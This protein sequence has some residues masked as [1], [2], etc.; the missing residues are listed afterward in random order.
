MTNKPSLPA[1][2][3][4]AKLNLWHR[5]IEP[6]S[7]LTD[8]TERRFARVLA[9]LLLI[10]LPFYFLPAGLHAIAQGHASEEITYYI[11]SFML[12]TGAYILVRSPYPRFGARLAMLYFSLLPWILLD[13]YIDRYPSGDAGKALMWSVLVLVLSLILLKP[14]Q[15]KWAVLFNISLYL[16]VPAMSPGLSYVQILPVLA[17]LIM[18]GGVLIVSSYV[19]SFYLDRLVARTAQATASETRYREMFMGSPV[20]LWEADFSEIKRRLDE[21]G[22]EKNASLQDYVNEHPE[23]MIGAASSVLLLDANQAAMELYEADSVGALR[24]GL[25]TIVGQDDMLALRDGVIDLWHGGQNNPVETTHKTLRGNIKQVVVR[26]AVGLGYDDTWKRVLI[27]IADVTRRQAAEASM[28][29]LAS[30]IE[31]SASSVVITDLDGNIEYVN[32]AFSQVTG[33][34]E[35]EVL[36]QNPRVLKSDVHDEAFY[37]LMW[38]TLLDGETWHGEL[39]NKKKNGELYWERAT[40]S[41]V[42]NDA[43][44]LVSYVAV[45]D[46]ITLVKQTEAEVRR[47]SEF[48]Q[49]VIDGIDSP[50]YVLNVDDYSIA[51]ANDKAQQVGMNAGRHNFCYTLT[52]NRDLPCESGDHPCPL[53]HVMQHKEPFTVEHIHYRADGSPYYVEVHGYPIY[54]ESGE[55][56]QMIE[57]SLDITARN[58]AERELRKLSNAVEQAANGIVITD[59]DGIIE[60]VNPAFSRITGYAAEEAIGKTPNLLKSGEHSAEYYDELWHTIENGNVWHGELVNRRRDGS[61]YWESQVISPVMN[62]SGQVTHYVAVKEDISRRKELEKS[63]TL[64]HE[65]ALVASDLKTKLLANVSHDMRT[66]LGAILGY[67]EMLQMGVFEPLNDAQSEATR[68]I[69]ASTQRLLDFVNNLLSQAQIETGKIVLNLAPFSPQTLLNSMGTEIAIARTKGLTIATEIDPDLPAKITSDSY[70]LGQ[71]LHNLISNAIKF[72]SAPGEISVRCLRRNAEQWELRITDTGKGIPPDA[73]AYI[74]ESFRQV[75]GAPNR[76]EHTGSGLGLSIVNHLVT[77]LN[78]SIELESELGV[79]ST[80]SIVLPLNS[81]IEEKEQ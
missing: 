61:L 39:V 56:V 52:H 38:E 9:F 64:A 32:P 66:P 72:T 35:A 15:I 75:D 41:P 51:L 60:F 73:Q 37:K 63:L 40:I 36:G 49:T 47:Q 16:V 62:N 58:E 14:T 17:L 46:D 48:L 78:G 71:I 6:S 28:R 53:K 65:A 50:F 26:F 29:Q 54:D 27:S 7:E 30:A 43:G 3:Q 1:S 25:H 42:Q 68:A 33:Y 21:L 80:F 11:V 20:A 31:A 34:S 77:L 23:V 69:S 22:L 55:V 45:K 12:L 24:E 57:Y 10:L 5:L 4:P 2:E 13:A 44:E 18:V 67:T 79:G 19:Q 76:L 81:A 8:E 59:T 74:F 70:W